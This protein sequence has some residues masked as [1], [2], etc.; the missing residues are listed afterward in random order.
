MSTPNIIDTPL[1]LS[2]DFV[3]LR[4]EG[5]AYIQQHSGYA[6]TNLNPSDPGVTILDQVCYALTELGYCNDFPVEDILTGHNGKLRIRDQFYLPEN[7]LTTSPLTVDDYRRYLIDGVTGVMNAIF[8]PAFAAQPTFPLYRVY[9]LCSPSRAAGNICTDAYYY[10]NR[11]RNIGELFLE[12]LPLQTVAYNLVGSI[13]IQNENDLATVLAEAQ[14]KIANYIFPEV[15]PRGYNRIAVNDITIDEVL[16]GPLLRNGWIDADALGKKKDHIQISE[17]ITLINTIPAVKIL[18]EIAFESSIHNKDIACDSHELLKIDIERSVTKGTLEVYCNGRMLNHRASLLT[19]SEWNSHVT[20]AGDL[21]FGVSSQVL[22]Q[23]P[24]GKFRHIDSY[25]SIQNTLPQLYSVGSHSIPDND[26]GVNA[27]KAAQSRQLKG[28][29]TLFDQVLANQFAQLANIGHLFS[30]NNSSTS[31]PADRRKYYEAQKRHHQRHEYPVPYRSFAPTYFYKSLYDIPHIKPLLKDNDAFNFSIEPQ[32]AKQAEKKAWEG[33]IHDPYNAYIHGLMNFTDNDHASLSRRN[34]L[35]DHLLARHGESP[36][37]FDAII[38]GSIYTGD[39]L[40]DRIVFKSLYLQNLGLLSY[41]RQKAYDNLTA[42]KIPADLP[43][44]PS[45]NDHIFFDDDFVDFIFN[46]GKVDK[47]EKLHVQDFINYSAAE[48]RL[49]LL[50]G[51]RPMY[52][53]FIISA[54]EENKDSEQARIALWLITNRKGFIFI[55]TALLNNDINGEGPGAGSAIPVNEGVELIFPAFIPGLNTPRFRS[56]LDLFLQTML[57]VQ[58]TYKYRFADEAQME[59]CITDFA[60]WH[61]SLISPPPKTITI[62]RKPYARI[63]ADTIH[64]IN[65]DE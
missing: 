12:P 45:G 49:H 11:S 56:R 20:Q 23:V 38:E 47:L 44:A 50:F 27:L 7:I 30:F 36:L 64:E 32:P 16:D 19:A 1:P 53:S 65:D 24:E 22:A 59:K 52:R 21:V 26:P 54:L 28:Y 29:L 35:L 34:V 40:R 3:R 46:S 25:Y 42:A 58:I 51:L 33:Y 2:Q 60:N 14:N 13:E 43:E 31:A 5:L 10:L 17:I 6:W 37:E 48:L 15:K 62:L 41:Y 61:N 9:L 8:E 55:E 4:D 18:S 57:P 39:S 63:L